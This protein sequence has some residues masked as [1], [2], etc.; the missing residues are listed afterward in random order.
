LSNSDFQ[1]PELPNPNV[2]VLTAKYLI[3][4]FVIA[5]MANSNFFIDHFKSY[6]GTVC[7][8]VGAVQM[9]IAQLLRSLKLS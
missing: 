8:A 3:E 5:N 1:F 7:V 6:S 9:A 4:S 2:G